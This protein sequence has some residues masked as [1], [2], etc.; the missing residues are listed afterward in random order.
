MQEFKKHFDELEKQTGAPDL[1]IYWKGKL[2]KTRNRYY[3]MAEFLLGKHKKETKNMTDSAR[4]TNVD[5][6][7]HP[8]KEFTKPQ[9]MAMV[10]GM[11]RFQ[12]SLL[13]IPEKNVEE[14]RDK[15]K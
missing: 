9:T 3:A 6:G 11:Q 14:R 2:T 13:T 7:H 8:G 10:K 4:A 15:R 12:S 1:G 5:P